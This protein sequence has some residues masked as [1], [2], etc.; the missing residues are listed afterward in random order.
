[1]INIAILSAAHLHLRGFLENLSKGVDGRRAYVVWDDVVE[2]GQRHAAQC[3]AKFEPDL[4]A[5]LR[6]PSVHGF[7]IAAE[8][9]RHLALL[10]RV[11]P[12]GK[13]VL[14]DKP[15][16][17]SVAELRA[18]RGLVGTKLCAGY[19]E[20][21]GGT[22]Q[23]VARLLDEG[24]LGKVTRCRFR[25]GH[26]AAYGRFFDNPDWGWFHEP[27]LSGGG[28]FLDLGTMGVHLLRT[29]FGP[30]TEVWAD[31]RNEAGTYPRVDDF[32]VA[33]LRFASGVLGTVEAA[34]TQTGGIGGLEV[35]GAERALWNTGEGYVV[36]AA[37][38]APQP[39]LPAPDKPSRVDRLV[40]IIRGELSEAELRRDLD[41]AC[42]AV[43]IVDAA[44]AAT[45]SGR[46]ERVIAT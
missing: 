10:E 11:V 37:K 46:W 33:H 42:D 4:D 16:V 29:L 15:L 22:M 41:A 39:L 43:A 20:P 3:G 38:A 32:G 27:A 5:V 6:D 8:N 44:Y 9:T 30:V 23:A 12:I 34:W 28:A 2:R 25:S 31:I 1:L 21:F 24:G 40:A 19:Y 35:V 17:T 13:P 14:C 45:R 26:H 7:L 18:L 36:A